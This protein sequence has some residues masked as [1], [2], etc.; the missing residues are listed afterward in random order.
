MDKQ[1]DLLIVGAGTSGLAAA[2]TAARRGCKVLLVEREEQ[3]GG[4]LLKGWGFPICGLFGLTET[5]PDRPLNDGLAQEWYQNFRCNV[6]A[7]PLQRMGRLWVCPSASQEMLT[8][9]KSAI[10]RT[11]RVQV[12]T[13]T[14]VDRVDL[15]GDSVHDV[16]LCQGETYLSVTPRM[17]VDC[18]GGGGLLELCPDAILPTEAGM[19]AGLLVRIERVRGSDTM[20]PLRVSHVFRRAALEGRVPHTL[21][22]TTYQ[23]WGD[24]GTGV[25]KMNVRPDLTPDEQE[26]FYQVTLSRVWALLQQEIPDLSEARMVDVSTSPLPRIGVRGDGQYVLTEDD[27]TNARTFT[28]DGVLCAWPMEYWDC[29]QGPQY[30]YLETGQSFE[31]PLGC[32]ISKRIDNLFFSGRCISAEERALSA[33]RVMGT[34][35]SLGEAVGTLAAQRVLNP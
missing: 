27:V 13:K 35:V 18:S 9:F 26:E 20:L 21:G 16:R 6:S 8:F 1:L 34:C 7:C 32:M 30:H 15:K 17:V 14:V 31:I 2:I 5:P 19:L 4:M 22:F 25:L 11:D 28:G 29:E 24:T 10:S 33:T 12:L 3:V 23:Q